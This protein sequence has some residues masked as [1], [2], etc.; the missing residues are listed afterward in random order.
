MIDRWLYVESE[1]NIPMFSDDDLPKEL[2]EQ[3]E[4]YINAINAWEAP[5]YFDWEDDAKK[6]FFEIIN[7]IGE[8]MQSDETGEKL[9]TYLSKMRTYFARFIALICSIYKTEVITT[10]MIDFAADLTDYYINTAKNTFIGFSNQAEIEIIFQRENAITEREKVIALLKHFP[11][12]SKSKIAEKC[13]C[14]RQTV[15]KVYNVLKPKV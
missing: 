9:S 11:E 3:Y 15:Y 10:T 13:K 7:N 8:L 4:R 5:K 1:N 6:L 12:M 2:A 14:S